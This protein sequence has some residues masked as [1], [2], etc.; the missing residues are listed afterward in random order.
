MFLGQCTNYG[1][2]GHPEN[3]FGTGMWTVS[4]HADCFVTRVPFEIYHFAIQGPAGSSFQVWIDSVFYDYVEQGDVNSWDGSQP[5]HL[6]PGKD[7]HFYWNTATGSPP[8][9]SA[10]W[11]IPRSQG[12]GY[13]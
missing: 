9:V 1:I 4:F 8:T 11:R 5:L 13:Y 7:V 2:V 3:P 6:Q 10:F 12:V